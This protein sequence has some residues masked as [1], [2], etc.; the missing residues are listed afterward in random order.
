VNCVR[1]P[2]SAVLLLLLF[3]APVMAQTHTYGALDTNNTWTG[4]QNFS[5]INI[6]QA[7]S[8]QI[9]VWNQINTYAPVPNLPLGNDLAL[10]AAGPADL[11]LNTTNVDTVTSQTINIGYN[12]S[13]T[14]GSTANFGTGS[15][16]GILIGRG[17]ANY[18]SVS[19]SNWSIVDATHLAITA[20]N[21]HTGTTDIEQLGAVFLTGRLV[22]LNC[23]SVKPSQQASC[24]VQVADPNLD[25][26]FTAPGNFADAWPKSALSFTAVMSGGNGTNG[27]FLIRDYSSSSHFE[28]LNAA[29]TTVLFE[30][31]DS[32]EE[33][34]SGGLTIGSGSGSNGLIIYGPG[35]GSPASAGLI[36]LPNNFNLEVRNA[37]NNGDIVSFAVTSANTSYFGDPSY[38]TVLR[39]STIQWGTGG[40]APGGGATALLNTVGGSGPTGTT[41]YTWIPVICPDN[42]SCFMPAWK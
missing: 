28:I 1:Q 10:N 9:N 11:R 35:G 42:S 29:N 7:V 22:I 37:G 21:S 15:G 38:P 16:V 36:R 5:N 33:T 32:G 39:G 12:P 18:E 34:L 27:D 26:L 13:V 19:S 40:V 30:M 3:Y 24:P 23:N 14:V 31:T 41:Q 20:A 2:L 25:I 4:Q 8:G 6:N 17:T